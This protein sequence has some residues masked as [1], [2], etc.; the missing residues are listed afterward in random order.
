MTENKRNKKKNI[1]PFVPLRDIV[2]FPNMVIPLLVGRQRSINAVED[3]MSTSNMI[4]L[5]FQR[6]QKVEDPSIN[7]RS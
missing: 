4:I 2:V 3:A 6:D 1:V 5:A 7:D